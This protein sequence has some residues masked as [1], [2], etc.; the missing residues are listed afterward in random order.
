[1][2]EQV[3]YSAEVR[4]RLLVNGS[5]FPISHMGPDFIRLSGAV[6]HPPAAGQV[7][8]V[9]DGHESCWQVFLP[10][11]LRTGAFR[12]PVERPN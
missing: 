8:S 10:E 1:M 5:S 9:V 4:M 12:I 11:G 2:P 6:E 3:G 7:V